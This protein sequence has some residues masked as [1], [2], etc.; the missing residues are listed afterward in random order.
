MLIKAFPNFEKLVR[1]HWQSFI[2][3]K[4]GENLKRMIEIF[5][6]KLIFSKVI[7]AFLHHL[8]PNFFLSVNHGGRHKAPPLFKISGSAP[9][10]I[11]C[12]IWVETELSI[13]SLF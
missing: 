12:Q 10:N 7:L 1:F 6:Q 13:Q 8:K 2:V 4:N 3:S 5:C 11:L 9:E